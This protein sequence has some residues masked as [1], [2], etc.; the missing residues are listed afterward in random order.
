MPI[1][2]KIMH[3]RYHFAK[4]Q[5]KSGGATTGLMITVADFTSDLSKPPSPTALQSTEEGDFG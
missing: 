2:A 1:N 3:S 4:A 5:K